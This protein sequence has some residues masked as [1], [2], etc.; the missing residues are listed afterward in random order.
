MTRNTGLLGP[1]MMD[2]AGKELIAED[3]EMLR[4][5]LVGGL[6]L[7]TRNYENPPQVHALIAAIRDLR[8]ELLVAVDYE[9]GRVQRFRQGFTVLPPARAFGHLYDSE[10]ARAVALARDCGWMIASE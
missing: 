5:P 3:S 2:I 1:L 10:R 9:G 6:I 8:P 4:H 7:F